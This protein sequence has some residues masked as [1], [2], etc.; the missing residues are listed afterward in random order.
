MDEKDIFNSLNEFLANENYNKEASDDDAGNYSDENED[1]VID[2]IEDINTSAP[3]KKASEKSITEFS[4]PE[5]FEQEE[6][7]KGIRDGFDKTANIWMPLMNG[8]VE[9][10]YDLAIN[11]GK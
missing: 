10:V 4:L 1:S 7:K 2:S 9:G 8:I 5:L 11:I 6:F 3:I